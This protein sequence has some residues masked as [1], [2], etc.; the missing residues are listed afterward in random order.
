MSRSSALS[1]KIEN[2]GRVPCSVKCGGPMVIHHPIS[3]YPKTITADVGQVV[4]VTFAL[5]GKEITA[6]VHG[7]YVE[8]IDNRLV[9]TMFL[10]ERSFEF[11]SNSAAG[12]K[13]TEIEI[14]CDGGEWLIFVP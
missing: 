6:N 9:S 10:D 8:V 13:D 3:G 2:R 4:S 11:V 14:L 7:D 12:I 1:V 5:G